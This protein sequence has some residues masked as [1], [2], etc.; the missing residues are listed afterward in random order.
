MNHPPIAIGQRTYDGPP[1]IEGLTA[2]VE[3]VIDDQE[4]V[5]STNLLLAFQ[6]GEIAT[7]EDMDAILEQAAPVFAEARL[8]GAAIIAEALRQARE[9]LRGQ[10][11]A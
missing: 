6:S 4:R 3:Q 7:E 11:D 10:G 9:S 2:W 1:T 8:N 5:L